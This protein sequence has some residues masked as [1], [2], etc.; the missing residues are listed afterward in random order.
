MTET[1]TDQLNADPERIR[2]AIRRIDG[3]SLIEYCIRNVDPPYRRRIDE[4]DA[5]TREQ[6]CLQRCGDCDAE[7]FLVVDGEYVADDHASLV[8]ALETGVTES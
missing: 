5:D 2:R 8:E 3:D 4:L 6:F 7:A 1:D